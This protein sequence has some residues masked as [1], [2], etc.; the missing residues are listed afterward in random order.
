MEI[1][2]DYIEDYASVYS[3]PEPKILKKLNRDTQAKVLQPRMMS[4]HLQ[5]RLLAFISRMIK[6]SQILE[7]G[8]YTG[9]SAL[10]LTEGLT[11]K[12]K[13]HTIDHNP[14]LEDF[15]AKFFKMAG[16]DREIIQY[17]GEAMDLIPQ[18]NE[19]FDLVFLDAD[20]KNY[21][22][23]FD[24]ILPRVRKGGVI[25]ADN[26]LWSGKVFEPVDERDEE[27][28]GIVRFNDYIRD[29]E[30]VRQLLLPV[31]DGLMIMEKI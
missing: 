1:L 10:C 4:G 20:K 23:Y 12:G 14:E 24:L 13:L 19:S 15:A 21:V 7:I 31:R 26:V 16:K 27:A 11:K 28:I 8:T 25:L 17:L 2:P 3:E 22:R 29:H 18:L 9:Y 5:G 30:G 6:P